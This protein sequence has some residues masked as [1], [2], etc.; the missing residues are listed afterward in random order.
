MGTIINVYDVQWY[1]DNP[2]S[3]IALKWIVY[4]H[5]PITGTD[6]SKELDQF[7]FTADEAKRMFGDYEGID[8][9]YTPRELFE[10]VIPAL[11][12]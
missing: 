8:D 4:P 12:S 3:D 2:P 10:K 6:T 9:W 5:D 1:G 7:A 11:R